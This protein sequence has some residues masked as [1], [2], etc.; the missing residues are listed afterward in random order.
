M[1]KNKN[2]FLGKIEKEGCYINDGKYGYFLTCNKKNYR[3]PDW[4][5][6]QEITLEM[7]QRYIEYKDK[8]SDGFYEYKKELLNKKNNDSDD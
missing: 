4:L 3:I 7:A 6:P 2:I 5:L 8:M 1:E